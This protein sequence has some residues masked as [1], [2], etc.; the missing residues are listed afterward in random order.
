MHVQQQCQGRALVKT[1]ADRQTAK[2]ISPKSAK[3]DPSTDASSTM[4]PG[5]CNSQWVP[6]ELRGDRPAQETAWCGSTQRSSNGQPSTGM[7]SYKRATCQA[8]HLQHTV[9]QSGS[10][11][12]ALVHLA[13]W[14][15]STTSPFNHSQLKQLRNPRAADVKSPFHPGNHLCDAIVP[16]LSKGVHHSKG[17]IFL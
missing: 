8:T 14:H 7:L 10:S 6:A 17:V 1:T 11:S 4:L 9:W 3:H 2:L 12:G 5:M 16:Q 13:R 15:M